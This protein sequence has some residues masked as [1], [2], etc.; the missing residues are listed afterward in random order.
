MPAAAADRRLGRARLAWPARQLCCLLLPLA[1]Q[2]LTNTHFDPAPFSLKPLRPLCCRPA[3]RSKP[4]V[5][6]SAL[7]VVVAAGATL[8]LYA[9]PMYGQQALFS[10]PGA[11]RFA[12]DA[13]FIVFPEWFE[14]WGDTNESPALRRMTEACAWAR[15]TAVLTMP[16][17]LATTWS[18]GPNL[19]IWSTASASFK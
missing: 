4:L 1:P 16:V 17:T 8:T 14:Q 3:T 6:G 12:G 11:V 5:L 10:G 13:E 15:C 19:N 18:V 9:Q 7:G 2:L